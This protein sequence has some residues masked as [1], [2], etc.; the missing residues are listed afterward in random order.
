V[1]QHNSNK[2]LLACCGGKG[3]GLFCLCWPTRN[4]D[5]SEASEKKAWHSKPVCKI[6]WICT[7][8]F[9]EDNTEGQK[10]KGL[11]YHGC[12]SEV[13]Y[14]SQPME[15]NSSVRIICKIYFTEQ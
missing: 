13:G 2:I 5:I 10:K 1:E 4:I 3:L 8:I 15:K 7:E 6:F 9:K 11:S 12:G 14:P